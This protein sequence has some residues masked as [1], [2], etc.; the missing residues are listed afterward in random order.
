MDSRRLFFA[1][2][3]SDRQRDAL[4]D[5]IQ[6]VLSGIE[7]DAIDRRNW[8]ITLVFVGQFPEQKLAELQAAASGVGVEPFRLR[9][10]RAS[11]WPR[12]KIACLEAATV[13]PELQQLVHRIHEVT[14]PFG[15]PPEDHTYR[16]H[17]TI[18]RRA[19]TFVT[20][21]LTR[22]IELQCD[23]FE[24]VESVSVRGGVQYHPVKQ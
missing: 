23:S 12:P 24:L 22:A 17:I 2:W 9:F 4:R 14:G 5:V 10:D 3:L 20:Q 15:V 8:H 19:R 6:P 11:F 18:A 13:P 7:G 21:R 16:P 1:L